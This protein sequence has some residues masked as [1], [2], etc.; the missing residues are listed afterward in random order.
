[1]VSMKNTLQRLGLLLILL[2]LL[3]GLAG[4]LLVPAGGAH[5]FQSEST[6]AFHHGMNLPA[7]L[8]TSRIESGSSLEPTHDNSC[9]LGFVVKISHPPTL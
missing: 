4:H 3:L 8:Q 9:V 7:K 6:C 1:M 2:L 5:H